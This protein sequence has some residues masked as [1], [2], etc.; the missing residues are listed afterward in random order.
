MCQSYLYMN[1]LKLRIVHM[2]IYYILYWDADAVN[3]TEN[4]TVRKKT[5]R[6]HFRTKITEIGRSNC[7][8]L[9]SK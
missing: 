4:G 6:H 3:Y 5:F 2:E 7:S 9:Q 8:I 1:V